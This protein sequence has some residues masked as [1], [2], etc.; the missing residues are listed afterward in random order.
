MHNIRDC[1]DEY[2]RIKKDADKD[3]L[4]LLETAL[5]I[6]DTFDVT[7][8]DEEISFDTCKDRDTI[9]KLVIK[10]LLCPK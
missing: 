7:L 10:K 2:L 1:I 6:E 8:A 4:Y 3:E 9:E 5:F